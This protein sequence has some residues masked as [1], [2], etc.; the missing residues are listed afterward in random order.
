MHKRALDHDQF[1]ADLQVGAYDMW[2]AEADATGPVAF[3]GRVRAR[4][5]IAKQDQNSWLDRAYTDRNVLFVTIE[6]DL[7]SS[8]L[9]TVSNTYTQVDELP[10]GYSLP[11]Y[12]SG[13]SLDLPRSTCLCFPW[14]TEDNTDRVLDA[15]LQQKFG[16]DWDLKLSASRQRQSQVDNEPSLYGAINNYTGAGL[17]LSSAQQYQNAYTSTTGDMKTVGAFELFGRRQEVYIGANYEKDL[18]IGYTYS[19]DIPPAGIPFNVFSFN[20][21]SISQP[22]LSPSVYEYSSGGQKQ[23]GANAGVTL[24]FIDPLKMMLGVRWQRFEQDDFISLPGIFS[25]GPSTPKDTYNRSLVWCSAVDVQ[26]ATDELCQL[27]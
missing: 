11:G 25:L 3:D 8:T 7:S 17:V 2:R 21:Y 16:S 22:A 23:Y 27:G 20:P 14:A 18:G 10:P 24:S 26:P 6:A 12:L 4:A 1:T 13:A 5:D 19:Y 9:L 15:S